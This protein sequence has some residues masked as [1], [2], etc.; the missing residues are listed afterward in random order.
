MDK[1]KRCGCAFGSC[2][3]AGLVK[4]IDK[5]CK[6]FLVTHYMDRSLWDVNPSFEFVTHLYG[7]LDTCMKFFKLWKD[8]VC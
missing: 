4:S 7:L 8:H 5:M 1:R 3:Y 6:G 2:F